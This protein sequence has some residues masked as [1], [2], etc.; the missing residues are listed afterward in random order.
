MMN[1]AVSGCG[2]SH[3]ESTCWAPPSELSPEEQLLALNIYSQVSQLDSAKTTVNINAEQLEK[4]RE[5]V[6]HALDE[7]Q[8]A[9]HESGFWS[10]LSKL[11]GS[12]LASIA[13]AVAAVAA[14][15]A[16]GGAAAAVLG[17]IA[18]AASLAA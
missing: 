1:A 18:A 5:Q 17:V 16:T 10:S 7:A 9:H 4:L 11:F 14:V 6:K 8:K 15:V 13:S 3:V 12:D 2:T